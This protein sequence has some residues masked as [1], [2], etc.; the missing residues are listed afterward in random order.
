MSG[1]VTGKISW[2]LY[3]MVISS[4]LVTGFL[5][6]RPGQNGKEVTA[7]NQYYAKYT[8]KPA[9]KPRK[10]F[11]E[12][13]SNPEVVKILESLY[14]HPDDVDLTVG[15]Y[16]DEDL[17]PGTTVPRS[18]L[19][20]SLFS[21]FAVGV[22]DRFSAAYS[23]VKC[24]PFIGTQ[25]FFTC[26]PSNALE[27]LLWTPHSFMGLK[28]H[29]FDSFWFKELNIHDYGYSALWR[30]ITENSDVKCLQKDP[31]YPADPVTNPVVCS[32]DEFYPFS[33]TWTYF[34]LTKAAPVFIFI[35]AI[36]AIRSVKPQV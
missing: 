11:A 14:N 26:T 34:F 2:N 16:L 20:T 6:T 18:Q 29:W 1:T 35:T 32:L 31:L 36:L 22:S 19:I 23:S 24:I 4:E 9:V 17:Y 13:S 15:Q 3:P 30:L 12:F 28:Y 33:A 21:L 27:Y 25:T 5:L 10:T 8:G 7:F